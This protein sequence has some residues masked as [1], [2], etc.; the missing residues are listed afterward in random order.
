MSPPVDA[1]DT[2]SALFNNRYL[3]SVVQAIAAQG[4]EPFTTRQLARACDI[5]DN[6]VRPVLNRLLA[7]GMVSEH[8]RR[9]GA[10]GELRFQLSRQLGWNELVAL[11]AK[12]ASSA[13]QLG[14]RRC[15]RVR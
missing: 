7:A 5:P 11:C 8:E 10:R 9:G 3:V 14:H 12:L 15:Q 6:L 1:S 13:G 4:E 2:G